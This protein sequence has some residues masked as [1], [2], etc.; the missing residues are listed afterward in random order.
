MQKEYQQLDEIQK[1]KIDQYLNRLNHDIINTMRSDQR[2][3]LSS[4]ILKDKF[5]LRVCIVNF[6]T[7]KEQ[8]AFMVDNLLNVYIN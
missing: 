8:K 2:I 7:T 5:V 3:L 4:T 1:S 6:R